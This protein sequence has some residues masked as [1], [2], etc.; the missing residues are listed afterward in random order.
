[1]KKLLYLLFLLILGIA[2]ISVLQNLRI[3]GQMPDL[4][5]A[6]VI[7]SGLTLEK[8]WAFVS[9]AFAGALK[10]SFGQAAFG[11]NT[12]FFVLWCFLI[13]K[14]TKEIQIDDALLRLALAFT[15]SFLQNLLTGIIYF[16]NGG[17]LPFGVFM[18]VLF[19]G[20]LYTAIVFP[21]F[22]RLAKPLICNL[23]LNRVR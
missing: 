16:Y 23:S 11:F 18:R 9:S 2:Q 21:L 17:H 1:M 13:I 10:D 3:F 15:V 5:L 4:L 6:G 20:S 14:I 7:F 19:L 22:Y 12:V 8:R